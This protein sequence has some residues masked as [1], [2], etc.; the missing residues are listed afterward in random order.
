M[1]STTYM[2]GVVARMDEL[3]DYCTTEANTV[4]HK[5]A[6]RPIKLAPCYVA[7]HRLVHRCARIDS[8]QIAKTRQQRRITAKTSQAAQAAHC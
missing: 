4:R 1:C 8:A 5:Q 2:R 6:H 3:S 7:F